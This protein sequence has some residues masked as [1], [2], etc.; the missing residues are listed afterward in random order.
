MSRDLDE[1]TLIGETSPGWF[2]AGLVVPVLS[3]TCLT[4]TIGLL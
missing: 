3:P 4:E 1:N 2:A